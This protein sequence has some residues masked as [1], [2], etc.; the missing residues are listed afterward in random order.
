MIRPYDSFMTQQKESLSILRRTG[1]LDDD[2]LNL[3]EAALALAV[4]EKPE[5]EMDSYR[6]HLAL[7][8]EQ[9]RAEGAAT[10][11]EDQLKALRRILVIQNKYQSDD[12]HLDD[13]R[14]ANLMDVIDR[15]Q[16]SPVTLGLLYLHVAAMM[17]WAM[18]GI[19]LSG[20]FLLRLSARDGSVLIDPF[21]AGQICQVEEIDADQL[22]DEDPEDI[23]DAIEGTN[24]LIFST[25]LLRPLTRRDVLLRLQHQV[26]RRQLSQDHVDAAIK[27][28]QSMILFAPKKQELWRELGY[29]QAER[30]HIRAAISSLEVVRDLDSDPL[31]LRQ[32]DGMIRELR[33]RLN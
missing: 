25:D 33:W 10:C 7:L 4:V 17:G 11:A 12:N 28:L 5:A 1:E 30:G 21:R 24:P 18:T 22:D 9:V 31:P 15:R 23:L 14:T 27:T 26:K 16:G 19:D 3:G 13:P 2:A 20:H 6:A 8:V 32:T 29:L